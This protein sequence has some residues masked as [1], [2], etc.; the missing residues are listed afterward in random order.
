[1]WIFIE[2]YENYV[3][4]LH[5]GVLTV[6]RP[7]FSSIRVDLVC[8]FKRFMKTAFSDF[9]ISGP[10]ISKII[11]ILKR[12]DLEIQNVFFKSVKCVSFLNL[13]VTE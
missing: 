10:A 9:E 6:C 7:N 12:L 11:L 4:I 1:M 13:S 5:I 3:F 2:F 8:V